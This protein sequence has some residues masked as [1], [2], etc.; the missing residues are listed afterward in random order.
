MK[1]QA[2]VVDLGHAGESF[3]MWNGCGRAGV[4]CEAGPGRKGG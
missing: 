2:S 4:G 3:L 1:S